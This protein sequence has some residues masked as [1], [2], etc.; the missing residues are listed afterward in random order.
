[1]PLARQTGTG[2]HPTP[3][4]RT[5]KKVYLIYLKKD[6]SWSVITAYA[7]LS[8]IRSICQRAKGEEAE[9]RRRSFP[10]ACYCRR[11]SICPGQ[12]LGRVDQESLRIIDELHP[13]QQPLFFLLFLNII[14]WEQLLVGKLEAG[15]VLQHIPVDL[16]IQDQIRGID[17]DIE[18]IKELLLELE[19]TK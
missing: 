7:E 1:M 2:R 10:S 19:K 5:D 17:R 3:T 9:R 18:K 6:R 16:S 12:R 13:I 15:G 14:I 11:N 4:L 8:I